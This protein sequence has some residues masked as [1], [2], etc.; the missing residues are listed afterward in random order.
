MLC[1]QAV[2]RV[3]LVD[4]EHEGL[5]SHRYIDQLH[6]LFFRVCL[7]GGRGGGAEEDIR[8]PV[9]DGGIT[10]DGVLVLHGTVGSEILTVVIVIGELAAHIGHTALGIYIVHD[11]GVNGYQCRR[12]VQHGKILRQFQRGIDAGKLGIGFVG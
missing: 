6:A 7:L 5:Q 12:A 8:V 2:H 10:P 11:G 4:E 1:G 3:F 9:H